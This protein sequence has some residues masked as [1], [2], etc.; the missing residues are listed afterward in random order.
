MAVQ[1]VPDS[2]LGLLMTKSHC[3]VQAG[4]QWR[5]LGSLQ[6]PISASRVQA[7]LLLHPPE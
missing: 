2:A 3:V 4:G 1:L 7:I 6:S 5:H